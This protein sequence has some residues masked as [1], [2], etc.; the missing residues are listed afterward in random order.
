[1]SRSMG[2]FRRRR[3]P[4]PLTPLIEETGGV[5][6][7]FRHQHE[8]EDAIGTLGVELRSIYMLSYRPS[9]SDAGR[10]TISV[11]VSVP[12]ARTHARPGYLLSPN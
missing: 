10:H 1:M 11:E 2:S 9:S 12:G 4:D 3:K 5:E 8:L 7:H 6:L